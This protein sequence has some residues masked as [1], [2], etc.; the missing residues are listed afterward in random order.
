[1]FRVPSI[2]SLP[3]ALCGVRPELG[4]M[5]TLSLDAAGGSLKDDPTKSKLQP[6]QAFEGYR[7]RSIPNPSWKHGKERR[8]LPTQ[9]N[10]ASL[11]LYVGRR[12]SEQLDKTRSRFARSLLDQRRRE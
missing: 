5:A 3:E 12:Q 10:R 6:V 2:S 1:M 11:V 4:K 7:H 9:R 8:R